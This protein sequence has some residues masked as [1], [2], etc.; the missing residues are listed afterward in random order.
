MSP[1][2]DQA[3]AIIDE[4]AYLV[5]GTA[6]PGGT[7]WTSPVY[8]AV[9]GYLDFYW[10]SSPEATHSRNIAERPEV[11]IVVFDSRIPVG[12]GQAVYMRATAQEVPAPDLKRGIEIFARRSFAHGVSE[13]NVDDVRPPAPFRLYR[14]TASEHSMLA[15][16][17][18]PD[19]RVPM[20]ITVDA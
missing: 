4:H 5:L 11:S 19:H 17:G 15:K 13:W 3:R 10:V 18:A 9:E 20:D 7:P 1:T 16:D 14:A 2:A 8:F 6:D 12:Q